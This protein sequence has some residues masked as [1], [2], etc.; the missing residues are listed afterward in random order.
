MRRGDSV[1]RQFSR[2]PCERV[3]VR[4][5]LRLQFPVAAPHEL[6]GGL[7]EITQHVLDYSRGLARAESAAACEMIDE[8]QMYRTSA[9]H[10]LRMAYP[11]LG[12]NLSEPMAGA[13][14]VHLDLIDHLAR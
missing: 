13:G 1:H 6:L 11:P 4:E 10:G 2:D 12:G 5:P 9:R 8:V 7:R 3:L 14:A